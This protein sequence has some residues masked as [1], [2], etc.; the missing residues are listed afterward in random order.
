MFGGSPFAVPYF[1]QGSTDAPAPDVFAPAEPR[2]IWY[3]A[4]ASVN[5]Q[6][7][8]ARTTFLAAPEPRRT[9]TPTRG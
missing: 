7:R 5:W 4:P 1:G 3:A 9:W 8:P 6:G 2:R